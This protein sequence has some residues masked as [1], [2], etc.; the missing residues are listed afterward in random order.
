MAEAEKQ[1]LHVDKETLELG[2]ESGADTQAQVAD[3]PGPTA[4]A[5]VPDVTKP[6]TSDPKKQRIRGVFSTQTIE[7]VGTGTTVR[8]TIQKTF[9]MCEEQENGNIQLQPLNINCVPSGPKKSIVKEEFLSKFSPEPEF[10]LHSVY[11][12]IQKLNEAIELGESHRNKGKSF[13][14]EFEYQNALNIDLDNVR[15]NFGLGLTYLSR[16]E[17]K[18]A[19]NIFERLVNLDAAFEPEH[20][21]LFND[22]GISLRKNKMYDQAV[23]YYTRALDL[24]KGDENLHYN[25]ARAYLAKNELELAVQHLQTALS[26]NPDLEAALHFLDWL[27]SKGVLNEEGELNPNASLFSETDDD[28]SP[29]GEAA[30]KYKLNL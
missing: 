16:G 19:D 7:K 9:W 27:K 23:D 3:A 29:N 10:Y 8:K 26:M 13:S 12:A 1:A 30:D 14:A 20:K 18:K 5:D 15:A 6:D 22:F 28:S 4:D 21:H 25:I 2:E 24:S 17:T 11:P